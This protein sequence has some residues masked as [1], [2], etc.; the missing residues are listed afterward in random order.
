MSA[1]SSQIDLAFDVLFEDLYSRDGLLR[2]DGVFLRHLA[3]AEPSLNARLAQARSNPE[4][5]AA[6]DRSDLIIDLAPHLEDFLG[7]LF[8]ITTEIQALAARHNALA[9][10]FA[11]KRKFIQKRA[12]SGVTREQAEATDGL[13]LGRELEAIFGEPLTEQSFF[14]HVS[15]WLENEAE[16]LEVIQ[17]AA[18][19]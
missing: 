10:L 5:L 19:Y 4:A 13:A 1:V 9:P 17:L 16:R 2:L 14:A 12:I 6:K 8:G 3:A 15:G 18:H 7:E 11:F